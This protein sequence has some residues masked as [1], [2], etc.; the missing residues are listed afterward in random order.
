VIVNCGAIPKDLL[1]SELF[2]H[3]K[4]AFTGA[5]VNKRGLFEEADGSS[6]FLDEIGEFSPELQVKSAS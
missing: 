1:E 4:G 2:E 3:V 6:L 5:I